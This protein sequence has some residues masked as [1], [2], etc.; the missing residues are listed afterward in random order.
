LENKE[1]NNSMIEDDDWNFDES[2]LE[3]EEGEG[4]LMKVTNL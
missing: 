1:N 3:D 4:N 2:K